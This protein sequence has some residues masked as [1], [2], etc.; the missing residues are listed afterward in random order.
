[1]I[2]FNGWVVI[3]ESFTEED[4]NDKLLQIIIEKIKAKI[5]TLAYLNENYT[6]ENLN[7]S[8]HLSIMADHNH[9]TEHI[10]DFFKWIS[11]IAIGSYGILYVQ[12][13]EDTSR[14]N[15]NQFVVWVMKKGTVTEMDDIYLSPVFPEIES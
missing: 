15:E 12:D 6:L 10:I 5:T 13:D 2:T 8:Y 3:Q 4:E 9:R 14:G 1:M 11:A 7:G